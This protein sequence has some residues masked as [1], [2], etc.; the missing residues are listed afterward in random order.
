MQANLSISAT[1]EQALYRLLRLFSKS[2][3]ALTEQFDVPAY[4]ARSFRINILSACHDN[5]M[6]SEKQHTRKEPIYEYTYNLRWQFNLTR[7]G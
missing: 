6:I 7:S 4:F 3:I 1:S 5:V 2:Q